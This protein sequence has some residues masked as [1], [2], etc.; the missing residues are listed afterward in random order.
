MEKPQETNVDRPVINKPPL[1]RGLTIRIPIKIPIG[2]VFLVTGLHSCQQELS[3][4]PRSIRMSILADS[5][6]K[7]ALNLWARGVPNSPTRGF[8]V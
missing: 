3:S 5:L 7:Y 4:Y 8:G 1:S 6:R 2:G